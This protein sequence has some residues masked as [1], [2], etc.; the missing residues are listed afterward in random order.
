MQDS[1]RS[2]GF[3]PQGHGTDATQKDIPDETQQDV[4]S[5]SDGET[6]RDYSVDRTEQDIRN[7]KTADHSGQKT[8]QDI[9]AGQQKVWADPFA[10]EDT[11]DEG[12]LGFNR[13]N[14]AFDK[15]AKSGSADLAST[16]GDTNWDALGKPKAGSIGSSSQSASKTP[17]PNPK[18]SPVGQ[19]FANKYEI[20]GQI[21]Q[22]G[23]GIVYK[24]NDLILARTVAIKVIKAN[25]QAKVEEISRFQLEAKSIAKLDHPNIIRVYE[26]NVTTDGDPYFVLEYIAGNSLSNEI[27]GRKGLPLIEAITITEQICDAL[28]HAHDAGVVHRDLKP[29][30]IMLVKV[31]DR[32][33]VKLLDFG[34]AKQF[35][36]DEATL[37]LLQLTGPGQ[38]FGSPHYMSPEQ[39]NGMADRPATDIYS[40][41]CMFFEMLTGHPP[42]S[43]G[44]IMDTMLLHQSSEVPTVGEAVDSELREHVDDIIATMMAKTP[45]ERYASVSDV[46]D[47][48]IELRRRIEPTDARNETDSVSPF[49]ASSSKGFSGKHTT[50]VVALAGLAILG[51]GTFVL[52]GVMGGANK[53]KEPALDSTPW[54]AYDLKGQQLFDKGAYKPA[55]LNFKKAYERAKQEKDGPGKATK[56]NTSLRELRSIYYVL[57]DKKALDRVVLELLEHP[58]PKKAESNFNQR[59]LLKE[60]ASLS[61]ENIGASWPALIETVT[62]VISDPVARAQSASLLKVLDEQL[63]QI[64]HQELRLEQLQMVQ[65]YLSYEEHF[66]RT[67]VYSALPS[68]RLRKLLEQQGDTLT[69]RVAILL[70]KMLHD[71]VSVD[72]VALA[73]LLRRAE[74]SEDQQVRSSARYLRAISSWAGGN[75]DAAMTLVNE[76]LS[77]AESQPQRSDIELSRFLTLAGYWHAASNQYELAIPLLKRAASITKLGDVEPSVQS[78]QLNLIESQLALSYANLNRFGDASKIQMRIVN[79]AGVTSGASSYESAV[80]L[81]GLGR[82]QFLA[83]DYKTAQASLESARK[84]LRG[85]EGRSRAREQMLV[86]ISA[87]LDKLKLVNGANA[88]NS[89]GI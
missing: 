51:A 78:G 53:G 5:P 3:Q 80:A 41:G 84:I 33:A 48:L 43:G 12:G 10:Q 46:K 82:I 72:P 13:Q 89:A 35:A 60:I 69:P 9:G 45:D 32:V 68:D 39:C 4:H 37:Q 66:L 47:E 44:S 61:K 27:R 36:V 28:K 57:E 17:Q 30:N 22:G 40:L 79:R 26:M 50:I 67:G 74:R 21:G 73:T 38:I 85:L 55:L 75:R 25:S 31:H 6:Q 15:T 34:I 11:S 58:Q 19:M 83:N 2:R 63:N 24:A 77:D 20:V 52:S 56:L 14:P 16:S 49:S 88:A 42:F 18:K 54:K 8:D 23:M 59:Q 64:G 87:L 1:T 86:S 71:D 7:Q 29:S 81:Y 76:L 62:A 65:T 70:V